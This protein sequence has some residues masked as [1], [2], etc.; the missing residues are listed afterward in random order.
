M[1][2]AF[3]TNRPAHYRTPIFE[4]VGRR[5]QVDFF[6]TAAGPGRWWTDLHVEDVIGLNARFPRPSE[7][8]FTLRGG[9]YD[10]VVAALGGRAHLV[11]LDAAVR[12]APMPIVVWVDMW[13]Y[14]ESTSHRLARPFVRR[15]LRRSDSIVSCGRHVSAWIEDETG[16]TEGVFAMPNAVDNGRFGRPVSVD[17]VRAQRE[18]FALESQVIACFVGR[19][20]REKGLDVLLSALRRTRTGVGLVIVGA[21]SQSATIME[22]AEAMGMADRVR[23]VGWVDQEHLPTIYRAC[24]YLVIPSVSTKLFT[25]PWALVANEAMN[26]RLPVIASSSVGAAAGGLVTD[27]ETGLGFLRRRPS[28]ACLGDGPSRW[29][30]NSA[31]SSGRRHSIACKPSHSRER[32]AVFETAIDYACE[33]RTRPSGIRA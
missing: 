7:L 6:F 8:F 3:V 21:G 32:A 11:A 14:P 2:V 15:L 22:K 16:R 26:S 5:S 4:L 31:R 10:C 20:E 13:A 23:A 9:G 30:R 12:W 25:E 17:E 19:L 33:S 1:K 18:A 27:G 28:R 24:D 29:I